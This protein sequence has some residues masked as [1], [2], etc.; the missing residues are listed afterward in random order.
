MSKQTETAPL[1]LK[2]G[3]PQSMVDFMLGKIDEVSE[4][5]KAAALLYGDAIMKAEETDASKIQT[6]QDRKKRSTMFTL[7]SLNSR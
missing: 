7:S 4:R 6:V 3:Y 2:R 1:I 5:V